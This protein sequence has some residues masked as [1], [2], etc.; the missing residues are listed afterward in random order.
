MRKQFEEVGL[1]L[2]AGS[3]FGQF[4]GEAIFEWDDISESWHCP[5]IRVTSDGGKSTEL[6]LLPTHNGIYRELHGALQRTLLGREAENADDWFVEPYRRA[7]K[8]NPSF[9]F[10]QREFI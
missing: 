5:S 7:E 6:V 8:R 1:E 2:L 3:V 10:D 9:R 4:A